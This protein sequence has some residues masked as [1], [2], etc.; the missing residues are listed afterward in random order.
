MSDSL[1]GDVA[2]QEQTLLNI[3]ATRLNNLLDIAEYPAIPNQ[4]FARLAKEFNAS[5][6]G[7]RK[8]CLGLAMPSPGTLV[9]MSIR[10]S[11]SIDY[12]LGLREDP[13]TP[14]CGCTTPTMEI[15][16]Y[17]LE[18]TLLP[19]GEAATGTF[20]KVKSVYF[21]TDKQNPDR[22]NR[23]FVECWVDLHN[24]RLRKG[25]ILL[26]D[27]NET[28]LTENGIYILKTPS[29][30]CVRRLVPHMD[31]QIEMIVEYG[32]K[33]DSSMLS[34]TSISFN[35][36]KSLNEPSLKEGVKVI[37]R[38]IAKIVKLDPRIQ[39]LI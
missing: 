17:L 32:D 16:L 26:V 1:N 11:A 13:T 30:L 31:G 21:E 5:A 14:D 39:G 9:R 8:W 24:P 20:Y 19:N 22:G 6:S 2:E 33:K 25:D 36:T 37:G 12:L 15:P 23:F 38:V 27:S 3:F 7:V 34:P 4:R 28:H 29:M 35:A 18:S 10:F